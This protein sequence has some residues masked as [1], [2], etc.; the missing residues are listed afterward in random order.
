MHYIVSPTDEVD[1][2]WIDFWVVGHED[3]DALGAPLKK[4]CKDHYLENYLDEEDPNWVDDSG[5]SYRVSLKEY[6]ESQNYSIYITNLVWLD[7]V[8]I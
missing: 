3:L 2:N 4:L 5:A 8:Y 1:F 7:G 6:L